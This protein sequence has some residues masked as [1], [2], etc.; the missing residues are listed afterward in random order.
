MASIESIVYQ[1]KD[2]TPSPILDRFDREPL[3]AALLIEGHGIDGDRKAGRNPK[4][5]VNLLSREWL[6]AV[7]ARGYK[8]GAGE[9]G[10]QIVV[11]GLAVETLPPGARLKLGAHA[12]LE[13]VKP[14]SG[15]ARLETA[16]GKTIEGVGPIGV[17]ARV[18]AG[19]RIAIG[20]AVELIAAH[21]PST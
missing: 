15:C 14:R 1:P 21:A 19:G 7:A 17:L 12:I 11:A 2:R 16:Q 13:I 18:V 20:E 8:S 3:E 4:R 6:N 9:W 5:Q 10:E